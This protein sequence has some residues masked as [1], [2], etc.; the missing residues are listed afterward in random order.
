MYGS[1]GWKSFS[2]RILKTFFHYLLAINILFLKCNYILI[3]VFLYRTI[4]VCFWKLLGFISDNLK[5]KNLKMSGFYCCYCCYASYTCE[6]F[7]SRNSTWKFSFIISFII[8]HL[9]SLFY[10][11]LIQLLIRYWTSWIEQYS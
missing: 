6:H 10:F 7:Q 11:F 9:L 5:F 3:V 4:F 8:F 1:L 2:F